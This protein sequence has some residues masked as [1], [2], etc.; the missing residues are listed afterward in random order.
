MK[1]FVGVRFCSRLEEICDPELQKAKAAS[2]KG[3]CQLAKEIYLSQSREEDALAML[4]DHADFNE[5]QTLSNTMGAEIN[6]Q[7]SRQ[8][9]SNRLLVADSSPEENNVCDVHCRPALQYLRSLKGNLCPLQVRVEYALGNLDYLKNLVVSNDE[10]LDNDPATKE[11]ENLLDR[12]G[13]SSPVTDSLVC[14]GLF[15]DAVRSYDRLKCVT[16]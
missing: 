15:E 4:Y 5:Y 1:D 16:F 13:W 12:V 10:L 7:E 14:R 11:A 2:F 9:I 8:I 6:E 3:D